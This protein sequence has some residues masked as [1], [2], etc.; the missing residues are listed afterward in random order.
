VEF[1]YPCSSAHVKVPKEIRKF[2]CT[3]RESFVVFRCW[4]SLAKIP[5]F[6][7]DDKFFKCH[8]ERSEESF[9]TP[10]YYAILTEPLPLLG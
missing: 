6:V 7:R 5:H 3:T 2:E 10:R 8:S 9:L 1:F 4:S